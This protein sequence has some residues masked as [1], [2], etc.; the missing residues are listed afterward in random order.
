MIRH[1]AEVGP[2][3]ESCDSDWETVAQTAS[4]SIIGSINETATDL[5]CEDPNLSV[6]SSSILEENSDPN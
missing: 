3:S 2:R 1:L 6:C 4:I 5:S